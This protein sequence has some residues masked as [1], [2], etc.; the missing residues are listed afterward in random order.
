MALWTSL[1][2]GRRRRR[3]AVLGRDRV[4]G[5]E[6]AEF[7]I[8]VWSLRRMR[9]DGHVPGAH[10]AVGEQIPAWGRPTADLGSGRDSEDL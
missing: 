7:G 1:T 2:G 5:L 4:V 6:C 9:S 3:L 8:G 10:R